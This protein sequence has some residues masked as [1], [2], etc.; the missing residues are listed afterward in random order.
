MIHKTDW[1]NWNVA[2]TGIN[3]RADNPG[4][5]CAVARSIKE[6]RRFR[7][8]LIGLGYDVLDAGLYNREIFESGYLIPYP[9]SGEQA[10]LERIQEVHAV[11]PIDAII[12]SLD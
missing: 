8:R 1:R 6:S 5:G 9:A 4:P 11:E 12:P 3:A 7:G 10:L 2:I